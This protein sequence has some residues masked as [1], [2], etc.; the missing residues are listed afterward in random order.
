MY[1][2]IKELCKEKGIS[3]YRLE[4]DLGLSSGSVCKWK[5][6]SPT[7]DKIQKVAKMLGCSIDE[8]LQDT[9]D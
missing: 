8:L 9:T 5:V 4:K 2:R 3:I 7:L 6:S 1:E